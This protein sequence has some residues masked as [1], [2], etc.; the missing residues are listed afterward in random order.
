VV[1]FDGKTVRGSQDGLDTALHMISAYATASGLSLG[2]E[3]VW[4]KGHELAGI[5]G[6]LDTLMLKGCIV[7]IDAIGCQTEIA[8]K[9]TE[10][11]GDY[12]LVV[13]DN[14]PKLKEALEEFFVERDESG[15]GCLHVSRH[16][17]VEKG[18][19]RIET[20]RASCV[21]T[22][23]GWMRRFVRAGRSWPGSAGSNRYARSTGKYPVSVPITSVVVEAS[24]RVK[25]FANAARAHWGIEN[26]LHWV[27]D[28]T[29]REDDCRMRKDHAPQN[30]SAL[31]KF[32]APPE[33][34]S[35]E[36][37]SGLFE[38]DL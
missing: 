38:G 14:Q 35:S 30:F 1:A 32:A 21:P 9:I 22:C 17:H 6:L 31:R 29:S 25:A 37:K 36:A 34:D 11:G 13:K 8:Q 5:K 10:R 20:R 16:N 23:A 24:S 2:Q 12:L 4:G 19:G 33:F 28:V 18:H 15:Y 27:L 7:T 3:G 26:G